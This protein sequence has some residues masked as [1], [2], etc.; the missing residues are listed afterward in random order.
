MKHIW[1]SDYLSREYGARGAAIWASEKKK[2]LAEFWGVSCD[3]YHAHGNIVFLPYL[4]WR[5]TQV[6]NDPE[7]AR[8]IWECLPSE[9]SLDMVSILDLSEKADIGLPVLCGILKGLDGSIKY[10]VARN[11]RICFVARKGALQ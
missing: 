6:I 4:D 11:G 2:E 1:S 10:K 9:N 3:Y 8:K 5:N 7:L